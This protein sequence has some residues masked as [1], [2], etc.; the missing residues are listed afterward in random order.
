MY[1]GLLC[2]TVEG[3][4][5]TGEAHEKNAINSVGEWCILAAAPVYMSS[6]LSSPSPEDVPNEKKRNDNDK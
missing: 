2:D 1:W 5:D 4:C 3:M 6:A